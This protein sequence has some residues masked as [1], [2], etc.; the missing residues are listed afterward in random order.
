[1]QAEDT[2]LEGCG[3]GTRRPWSTFSPHF[4]SRSQEG[5]IDSYSIIENLLASRG[6]VKLQASIEI[7]VHVSKSKCRVL[8]KIFFIFL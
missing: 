4:L 6:F 2:G 1:M 5:T 8:T 3:D 7:A